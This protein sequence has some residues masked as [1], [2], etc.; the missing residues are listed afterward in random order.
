MTPADR[1]AA[2]NT[3]GCRCA[4]GTPDEHRLSNW[5]NT[6]GP[7]CWGIYGLVGQSFITICSCHSPVDERPLDVGFEIVCRRSGTVLERC[8][9]PPTVEIGPDGRARIVRE[10]STL[11]SLRDTAH[12]VVEVAFPPPQVEGPEGPDEAVEQ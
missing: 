12:A 3:R 4:D 7:P 6:G 11:P 5:H 10:V 8:A 1:A 9:P 2:T